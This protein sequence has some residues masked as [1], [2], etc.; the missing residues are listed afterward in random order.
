VSL[1]IVTAHL[2]SGASLAAV[3]RGKSVDTTMGF[4]LLEGL[5]MATRAGTVGPGLLLWVQNK[6]GV[7][8]EQM[9]HAL[10]H[11]SG[12]LGI[13]GVSGDL[14]QLRAGRDSSGRNPRG[15][16]DRRQVPMVLAPRSRPVGPA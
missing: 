8:A 13:W 10:E 7:S 1:R 9:E 14:R 12:L 16:G 15:S 2:G 3:A 4:T 6:S 5:V 11:D